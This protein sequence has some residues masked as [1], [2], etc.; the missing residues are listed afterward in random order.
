MAQADKT[1]KYP[2]NWIT[3]QCRM[4]LD[5]CAVGDQVTIRHNFT[6]DIGDPAQTSSW[7]NKAEVEKIVEFLS[8]FLRED[9]FNGKV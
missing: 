6:D 8:K 7:H 1:S 5:V 2:D 3:F 9:D 4:G